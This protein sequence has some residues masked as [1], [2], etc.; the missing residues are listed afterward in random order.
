MVQEA[1]YEEKIHKPQKIHASDFSSPQVKHRKRDH[2]LSV[3]KKRHET[4]DKT[5][6]SRKI[7]SPKQNNLK[8]LYILRIL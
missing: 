1:V 8:H 4:R 7:K 2:S 6:N 5:I 3:K